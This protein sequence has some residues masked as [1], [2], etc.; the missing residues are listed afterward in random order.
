MALPALTR[1]AKLQ[2]RAARVGFDWP[3]LRPV[4]DKIDEELAELR[5]ELEAERKPDRI[6]DEVGDLLFAIVN[7]ARHLHIDPEEA[8]RGT[9]RKFERRFGA[10][11]RAL[12]EQGRAIE[13]ARLDELEAF[14]QAAKT[15]E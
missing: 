8:L 2:R 13:A 12:S 11:E 10:I 3:D 9:N 5:R 14:W 1:A 4:L 15:Q 6:G 7:L